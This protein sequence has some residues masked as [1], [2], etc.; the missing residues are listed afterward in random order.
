MRDEEKQMTKNGKWQQLLRKKW[1]YPA[2]YLASAALILTGVLW[3]QGSVDEKVK[4]KNDNAKSDVALNDEEAMPVSLTQEQLKMPVKNANSV[5]IKNNFYDPDGTKEER[6][7]AL[8]FHN[9]TYRQN[10]G[11]DIAM[12]DGK[13]FDVLAALSGTVV[14]VENDSIL[15]N[16]IEVE[17]EEGVTTHYQSMADVAVEVG[18]LVKQGDVIG[19]AGKSVYNKDA[20]IHVHFEVRKDG[21]EL[22]PNDFFNKPLADII[23]SAHQDREEPVTTDKNEQKEAKPEDRSK[24]GTDGETSDDRGEGTT[25]ETDQQPQGSE[26][27]KDQPTDGEQ[28]PESQTPDASIGMART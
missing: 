24:E 22:N 12:E 23:E 11:I 19:T 5:V 25:G 18:A 2:I 9:N 13:A 8:V 4:D 14:K 21:R 28:S 16:I 1:V 17:H 6:E 10:T 7:N 27:D 15:G 20:G 3:Y 26:T